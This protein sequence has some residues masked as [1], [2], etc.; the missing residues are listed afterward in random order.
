M[1]SPS[2]VMKS[3]NIHVPHLLSHHSVMVVIGNTY[4]YHY[5]AAFI[6]GIEAFKCFHIRYTDVEKINKDWS[7]YV[8]DL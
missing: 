1:A 5:T 6:C 8:F 3:G 2:N 4:D 7:S